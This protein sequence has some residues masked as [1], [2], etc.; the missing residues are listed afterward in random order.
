MEKGKNTDV[1]SV[2]PSLE[3]LEELWVVYVDM[4]KVELRYWWEYG[5]EKTV[6][7]RSVKKNIR[8]HSD[9]CVVDE[10][11]NSPHKRRSLRNC[12]KGVE[13]LTCDGCED[14]KQV[15]M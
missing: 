13:F 10:N 3:R 15:T 1:S 4:Q 11:R 9:K 6:T 12:E 5:D 2:S 14:I 7:Q 8:E